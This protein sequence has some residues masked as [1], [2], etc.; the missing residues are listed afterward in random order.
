MDWIGYDILVWWFVVKSL[1]TIDNNGGHK[2]QRNHMF[3]L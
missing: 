1:V 2:L 3:I